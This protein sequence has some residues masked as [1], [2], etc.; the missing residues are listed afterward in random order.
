MKSN[1]L[2]SLLVILILLSCLLVLLIPKQ[3]TIF[4]PIGESSE[5]VSDPS[6][7]ESDQSPPPVAPSVDP[8]TSADVVSSEDTS[9]IPDIS[10]TVSSEPENSQD[11]SSGQTSSDTSS[12]TATGQEE[13]INNVLIDKYNRAMEVFSYSSSSTS[14]K[15]YAKRMN[16]LYSDLQTT[17]QGIKLYSMLVPKPCAYY[18]GETSYAAKQPC[19]EIALNQIKDTLDSNIISVDVYNALMPHTN[20]EIYYRTDFHWTQLGAYYGAEALAKAA[21]VSFDPISE[22]SSETQQAYFLGA[23]YKYTKNSTKLYN[24]RDNF[25]I[26]KNK[27]FVYGTDYTVTWHKYSNFNSTFNHDIF[28][29]VSSYTDCYMTYLAGDNNGIADIKSNKCSNG[30]KI[31]LI[32]NS[33][34]NPVP[35]WLLSS[36]EEIWVMDIRYYKGNIL[37]FVVEYDISDVCVVLDIHGALSTNKYLDT[38]RTQ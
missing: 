29:T 35:S 15:T 25:T 24:N 6:S 14:G 1:A 30:R 18:I 22:Y 16:A 21:G 13:I 19:T 28:Y 3:Q 4:D 20:E 32:K 38:I 12:A 33:Y 27:N 5:T 9:Y 23:L 36:F 37:D 26:Y 2:F 17:K 8:D 34:G 7:D 31:V 10:Q 11:G